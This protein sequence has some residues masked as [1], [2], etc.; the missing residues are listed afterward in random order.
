MLAFITPFPAEIRNLCPDGQLGGDSKDVFAL[1]S[2]TQ[3]LYCQPGSSKMYYVADLLKQAKAIVMVSARRNVLD[4]LTK[5]CKAKNFS[6]FRLDGSHSVKDRE[7]AISGFQETN[8]LKAFMLSKEAGG[9]GISLTSANYL[10][11][12]EPAWNPSIDAQVAARIYRHG[13]KK[14][15]KIIRLV[16]GGTWEESIVSLQ[17]R[18]MKIP[19]SL[20]VLNSVRKKSVVDMFPQGTTGMWTSKMV[21]RVQVLEVENRSQQ[22]EPAD[23]TVGQDCPTDPEPASRS[24]IFVWVCLA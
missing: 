19:Q 8:G 2:R 5:L 14:E 17:Q 23:V 6:T 18:K 10:L 4:A 15:C 20:T 13:Q 24:S 1:I 7:E 12:F 11:I 21:G 22:P 3:D 16:G 9:V